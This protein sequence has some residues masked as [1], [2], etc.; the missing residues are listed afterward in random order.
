MIQRL[1]R[2]RVAPSIPARSTVVTRGLALGQVHQ[3]LESDEGV[4]G[5]KGI[6]RHR[7]DGGSVRQ[8]RQCGRV[9]AEGR[10]HAAPRRRLQD[11]TEPHDPRRGGDG[12]EP[13]RCPHADAFQCAEDREKQGDRQP[14]GQR[15]EMRDVA[16][17]ARAD[18]R[19]EIPG[20]ES[21]SSLQ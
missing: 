18:G 4:D 20:R 7:R 13:G 2:A 17:E 15:Y 21:G 16:R 6:G 5:E 10:T 1:N 8:G 3:V 12:H 11:H 19:R 9:V 14:V